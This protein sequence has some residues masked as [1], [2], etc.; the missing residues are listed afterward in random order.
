MVLVS[1]CRHVGMGLKTALVS[2]RVWRCRH[3]LVAYAHEAAAIAACE[4]V[5]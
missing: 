2:G 5:G 3:C 1:M 4:L